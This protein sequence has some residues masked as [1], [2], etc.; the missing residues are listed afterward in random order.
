[1][2]IQQPIK[3]KSRPFT[4]NFGPQHP[5]A[6]G[7]L[8]L[9][10][11]MQGEQIIKTDT[12]IG[13]LHRGTEKL[14]EYKTALQAL[15]YFDRLDYV[16]VMAMEHSFCLAIERLTNTVISA[17]AKCIRMLYAELTRILNHLLAV[18]CFAMDT[19]ALTP[20]LFAFE[21]R[22]K[23]MEFYER[24]CGA[25]MHSAYFRPG[26]V[27]ADL[28]A[29][30]L[31][32]IHQWADQFASRIDEME[33]LLTGNRIF[34][35]RLVDIGVL[36]AQDAIAWG[37]S[38]VLLR[39]SGI[40]YDLRKAQPYELYDKVKFNVPVGANSDCY[41]RYLLRIEEMRQS[42]RI[43]KQ[44]IDLMPISGT[45]LISPNDTLNLLSNK[46]GYQ[47]RPSRAEFKTSMEGLI[48]HFKA[49][50]SGFALPAGE[51][52]C[53]TEAP[54]GEFGVL[55]VSNGTNRPYR[56]KI[57][58]PDYASLQAIDLIGR[59]HYLADVVAIIGSLDVVFGSI[60]R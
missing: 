3:P 21:E 6:H 59:G 40:A 13:L 24:V 34:K 11:S 44:T 48:K 43:I 20:F 41:D 50:S 31:Q 52:Y 55:C 9:I 38:G 51:T 39:G 35:Q 27:A 36:N 49:T 30:I 12:H 5:A 57:K 23:L 2:A 56:V 37:V 26:G 25:R 47:D 29:G 4:L 46:G 42:L 53:A 17:R 18:S 32:S 33:E 14:I 54:K 10:L 1:M 28:P 16:S 7:V 15:P 19:G 22:E 8:R 60:D 45:T 58:S